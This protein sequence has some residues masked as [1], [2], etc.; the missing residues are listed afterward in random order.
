MSD[1]LIHS[2][3]LRPLVGCIVGDTHVADAAI[4][5]AAPA[6]TLNTAGTVEP[7]ADDSGKCFGLY[8][9]NE[10]KTVDALAGATIAPV[11]FGRVAGFLGLT[12]GTVLYLSANA[13]KLA[14][15]GTVA[16]AYAENAT[17]AMFMPG[18]TSAAS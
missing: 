7:T 1:I 8:V 17:V 2:G 12:P 9:G 6:R 16:V 18:I 11:I 13:G 4:D 5:H 3:G 10:D 14:T 15:T